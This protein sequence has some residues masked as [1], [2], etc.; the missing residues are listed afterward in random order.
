MAD[1][2]LVTCVGTLSGAEH[3]PERWGESSLDLVLVQDDSVSICRADGDD[4]PAMRLEAARR[5]VSLLAPG[6]R[7]AFIAFGAA[8][9]GRVIPLESIDC[10]QDRRAAIARME[11]AT[12]EKGGT[13]YVDALR[14]VIDALTEGDPAYGWPRY[15]AEGRTVG[16]LFLSDGQPGAEPYRVPDQLQL[17]ELRSEGGI[18]ELLRKRG[19]PVFTIGVGSAARSAEAAAVLREMAEKTGGRSYVAATRD[20]L[21]V[22]CTA[23]VAQLSGAARGLPVDGGGVNGEVE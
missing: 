11:A 17:L 5:A 16:V 23:V 2:H 8:D 13:D 3:P 19:W 6:A 14:A 1:N 21:L 18:Y 12:F 7:I 20:E 15:R 22:A 10:D 4:L 9:Q